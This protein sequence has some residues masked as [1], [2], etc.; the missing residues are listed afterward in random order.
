MLVARVERRSLAA[1]VTLCGVQQAKPS[2]LVAS[3]MR[4]FGAVLLVLLTDC[5]HLCGM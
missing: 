2:S 3:S 4:V 5:H 1:V